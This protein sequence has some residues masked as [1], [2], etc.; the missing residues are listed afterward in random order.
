MVKHT[1]VWVRLGG[2]AMNLKSGGRHGWRCFVRREKPEI[3]L[4]DFHVAGNTTSDNCIPG[5]I[6]ND[7]GRNLLI[8]WIDYFGDIVIENEIA[9]ITLKEPL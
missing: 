3:R 6:A 5:S 1:N 2:N 9:E 8:A 7:D 4:L